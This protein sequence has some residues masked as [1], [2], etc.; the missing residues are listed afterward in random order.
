MTTEDGSLLIK[1]ALKQ[2]LAFYQRI[3]SDPA[4]AFI[5]LKKYTPKFLGTLTLEGEAA[6]S[7][8]EG[9]LQIKPV[10]ERKD[11]CIP[12]ASQVN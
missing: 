12:R 7:V 9:T 5:A 8:D 1:P 11:E 6:G 10:G 4:E 3:Q 2:E